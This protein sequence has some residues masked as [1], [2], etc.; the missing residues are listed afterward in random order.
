MSARDTCLV[1]RGSQAWWWASDPG[2]VA[3]IVDKLEGM[4]SM[5]LGLHFH[6]PVM[7]TYLARLLEAF[8]RLVA[9][10]K[11]LAAPAIE[12]VSLLLLYDLY[13]DDWMLLT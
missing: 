5:L 11:Q 2:T 6:H 7:I 9:L 12:K 8:S 1:G 10:R 13:C 3:S 4:F